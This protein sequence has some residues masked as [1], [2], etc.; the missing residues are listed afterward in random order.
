MW[1]RITRHR[2]TTY[3]GRIA[4]VRYHVGKNM[5]FLWFVIPA[6]TENNRIDICEPIFFSD[7]ALFLSKA[8]E[9]KYLKINSKIITILLER[10]LTTGFR[11]IKV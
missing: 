8:Q 6:Y 11:F 2:Q 4:L 3:W 7:L 9:L 1:C 5:V 10:D